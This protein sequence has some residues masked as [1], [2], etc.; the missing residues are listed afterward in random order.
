MNYTV[1]K[2][3]KR[4]YESFTNMFLDY[5]INDMKVKYDTEK[6]R[7]NLIEKTIL[8]QYE[9]NIIFIDIIKNDVICGFIIYQIDSDLSDWNIRQGSGYIREFYI[10]PKHRNKGLGSL[11]LANA[12]EYLKSLGVYNIYLTSAEND[13]VKNFYFKNNYT[14]NNSRCSQ[15][16]CII[17]EKVI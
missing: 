2:L 13:A 17:F 10:K 5:F 15:N 1:H 8:K 11:L 6:L 12:E 9:Q 14:T 3:T 7:H 16:D 4:E